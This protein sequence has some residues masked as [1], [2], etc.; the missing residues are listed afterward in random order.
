MCIKLMMEYASGHDLSK[1]RGIDVVLGDMSAR[2][3]KD[4][5]EFC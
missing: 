5:I 2:V 3:G 1:E 4:V